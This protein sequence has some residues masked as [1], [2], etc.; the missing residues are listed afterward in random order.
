M[1]HTSLV[2]RVLLNPFS[3]SSVS[4]TASTSVEP[5]ATGYSSSR[6]ITAPLPLSKT[7]SEEDESRS[8]EEALIEMRGKRRL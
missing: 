8:E 1:V 2:L 5:A 6:D 4:V 3:L 7:R